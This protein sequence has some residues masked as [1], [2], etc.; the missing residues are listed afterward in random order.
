MMVLWPDTAFVIAARKDPGPLSFRLVTVLL[1]VCAC[2]DRTP[3]KQASAIA[4]AIAADRLTL[5][6]DETMAHLSKLM[7]KSLLW[8]GPRS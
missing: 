1:A 2:A 4:T 5:V 6:I 3:G 8:L 7:V